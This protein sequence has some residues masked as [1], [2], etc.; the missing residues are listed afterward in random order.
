MG[1]LETILVFAFGAF[2]L[3]TLYAVFFSKKK[4][5]EKKAKKSKEKKEKPK[6]EKKVKPEKKKKEKEE[7][8]DGE[9]KVEKAFQTNKTQA[10]PLRARCSS[11]GASTA[12]PTCW[13]T[14]ATA[15]RPPSTPRK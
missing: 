10:A 1:T 6:K 11:T 5:K 14:R 9:K 12:S 15:W 3:Y 7:K 13:T 8:F 2:V 4:K